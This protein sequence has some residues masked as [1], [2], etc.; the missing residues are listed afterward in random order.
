[1]ELQYV[2]GDT[3]CQGLVRNLITDTISYFLQSIKV[4]GESAHQS[5]SLSFCPAGFQSTF[6]FI[7]LFILYF[8]IYSDLAC[9]QRMLP[10]LGV[11]AL[12]GFKVDFGKYLVGQS[13]VSLFFVKGNL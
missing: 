6:I 1:M 10:Y 3:L 8:A 2:T 13:I 9:F 12:G 4:V 5:P 7:F 11:S